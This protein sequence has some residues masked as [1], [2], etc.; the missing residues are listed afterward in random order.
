[1]RMNELLEEDLRNLKETDFMGPTTREEFNYRK[2]VAAENSGETNLR[3][4]KPVFDFGKFDDILKK[5]KSDQLKIA[6]SMFGDN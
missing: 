5:R 6:K 2:K 1:M 4:G 3:E